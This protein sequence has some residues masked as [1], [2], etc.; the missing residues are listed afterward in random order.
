MNLEDYKGEKPEIVK[1]DEEFL[2]KLNE[3]IESCTENFKEH[4]YSK[5]RAEVETF[6]WSDFCDNYLESV[7]KILYNQKKYSKEQFLSAQY[8]LY[9][10]LLT[11]LKII[12][13]IMPFITEE[14]Y[15]KYFKKNE[16]DKSI[17]ISEWPKKGK[18]KYKG[19][20]EIIK[21]NISRVRQEKSEKGLP[22]N[23]E[24][25]TPIIMPIEDYDIIKNYEE[26]FLA[27]S[28]AICIEPGKIFKINLEPAGTQP[29]KDK[30]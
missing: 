1:D 25:A 18:E 30:K 6:F 20:W 13:P 9:K 22:L 4:S 24:I 14:I 5:V 10:S 17:H 11:I 16:K 19:D 28:G 21:Y 15:Q 27:T 26:R 3:L 23:T 8:T 29:P 12:A 2:G 7:K